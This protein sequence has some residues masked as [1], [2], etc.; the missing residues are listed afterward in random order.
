MGIWWHDPN[1][2]D[3]CDSLAISSRQPNLAG[4]SLWLCWEA[5][6]DIVG[7]S[8]R[9]SARLGPG[10]YWTWWTHRSPSNISF[11]WSKVWF[12]G[13]LQCIWWILMGETMVSFRLCNQSIELVTANSKVPGFRWLW[14]C[15]GSRA[16]QKRRTT[17]WVPE[18]EIQ[19]SLLLGKKTV[20]LVVSPPGRFAALI[21]KFPCLFRVRSQMFF[22]PAV[23]IPKSCSILIR[24]GVSWPAVQVQEKGLQSMRSD[25]VGLEHRTLL[26]KSQEKLDDRMPENRN[27]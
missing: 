2:W 16:R 7:I 26:E 27:C 24:G 20:L 23:K 9:F 15:S 5:W 13:N 11:G 6:Q 8:G 19:S 17:P 1:S 3:F 10:F 14:F 21:L 25:L 12:Y 4:T 22:F 18:I